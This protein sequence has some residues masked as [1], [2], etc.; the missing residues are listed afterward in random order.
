MVPYSMTR[1]KEVWLQRRWVQRRLMIKLSC[2]SRETRMAA[3]FAPGWSEIRSLCWKYRDALRRHRIS[4]YT[5]K[6]NVTHTSRCQ[7]HVKNCVTKLFYKIYSNYS[8]GGT[9]IMNKHMLS[10]SKKKR[11]NFIS[12]S[13]FPPLHINYFITA[14]H[15]FVSYNFREK[16]EKT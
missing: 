9:T 14:Y 15:T 8:I 7:K 4:K 1:K 11:V 5:Y 6:L 3:G 16:Q 10:T 12:Y 13:F 2:T